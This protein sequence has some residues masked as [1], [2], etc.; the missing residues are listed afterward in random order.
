M[1]CYIIWKNKGLPHIM[2][3]SENDKTLQGLKVKQ[4]KTDDH[5]FK[6]F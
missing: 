3:F 4:I 5:K 6:F 2:N 1:S